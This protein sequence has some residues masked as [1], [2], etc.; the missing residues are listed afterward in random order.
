MRRRSLFKAFVFLLIIPLGLSS[1]TGCS[2]MD[3]LFGSPTAEPSATP[4]PDATQ[5]AETVFASVEYE[6]PPNTVPFAQMNYVTPDAAAM[7][8]QLNELTAQIADASTE[9][10][11]LALLGSAQGIYNNFRTA[12]TLALIHNCRDYTDAYWQE[13][14]SY[15][16]GCRP[17][18]QQAM[19]AFNEALSISAVGQAAGLTPNLPVYDYAAIE[20]LLNMQTELINQYNMMMATSTATYSGET[21][22]FGECASREMMENWIATNAEALGNIYIQLVGVRN[23]IAAACGFASYTEFIYAVDKKDYTPEMAAGLLDRV[24]ASLGPI[25]MDISTKGIYSTEGR[26]TQDELFDGMGEM[27]L[28]LDPELE[29]ALDFMRTYNLYDIGAGVHK[30]ATDF[31]AYLPDYSA[32]YLFANFDST[33]GGMSAVIR[34]FGSFY[35]YTADPDAAYLSLDTREI[36]SRGLELISTG[37]YKACFSKDQAYMLMYNT[38]VDAYSIFP[39]QGYVGGFEQAVYALPPEALTYENLCSISSEQWNRFGLGAS[40]PIA[41]TDWVTISDIFDSPM[42]SVS[43]LTSADIAMQLWEMSLQDSTQAMEKYTLLMDGAEELKFLQNVSAAGLVS[44]FDE[45]EMATQAEFFR[46]YLIQE[47]GMTDD[48]LTHA[49][50]AASASLAR[51]TVNPTLAPVIEVEEEEAEANAGEVYI[52]EPSGRYGT[53]IGFS[54]GVGAVATLGPPLDPDAMATGDPTPT[55]TR[56]NP[57]HALDHRWYLN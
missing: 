13:Q 56:A 25:Y 2:A 1:L 6:V 30:S 9:E 39:F 44:P 10:E 49:Q 29:A 50:S 14:Y 41:A 48:G 4:A 51:P 46:N 19:N 22:T 11:G 35:Q 52:P 28:M 36:F 8:A 27:F 32:P 55:P 12:E 20:P 34:Q 33:P 31:T 7:I 53:Y 5:T 17:H 18:I 45:G 40:N 37:K 24:A 43:Y 54:D 21:Y 26:L 23:Q 3:T 38:L 47:V 15:C 57:Y 16:A 42:D